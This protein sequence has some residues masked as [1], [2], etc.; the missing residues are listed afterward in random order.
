MHFS[1]AAEDIQM[2]KITTFLAYV[3]Q[4]EE[5]AKHYVSIFK[6]SKITSTARY[7]EGSPEGIKPGSIMTV[8]FTLD[9]QDYVAMN[10]GDHFK[11]SDAVSL[12]IGAKNQ[13]EVD[14]YTRRLLEGGGEQ[15]PCGWVKDRFGLRWQVTPTIL[16]ELMSD[17]D[18]AKA[19][20][21]MEAML[22]MKKLDIA[23]LQ[24]AYEQG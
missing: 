6:N 11:F 24:R 9:G 21:V 3:D 22:T 19:G 23:A 8:S 20:K 16:A 5:A 17:P 10:G 1:R 13:D 4:A 12:Q 2:P 14:D 7:P 18:R 15:L